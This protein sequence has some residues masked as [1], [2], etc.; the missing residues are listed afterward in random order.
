MPNLAINGGEKVFTE[1]LKMVWPIFDEGEEKRIL[2]VLH[3]GNWW[4]GAYS[5]A[6]DSQVGTFEDTFASYH[7]AKHA[8]AKQ[9]ISTDNTFWARTRPP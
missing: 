7:D 9:C 5:G 6:S 1:P 3:S 2:E 8:I 4:R